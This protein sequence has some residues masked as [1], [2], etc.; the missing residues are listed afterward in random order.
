MPFSDPMAD[1]P[2]VQASSL[3]ALKSGQTMKK[4]LELVRAFR[5]SD[6]DTPIVLMGYYNPVYVY[7]ARALP[8][9]RQGRRRRRPHHRRPA[10]R[11]R[12]GAVPAGHRPR[13]QLHPPGHA[14]HGRQA[15]AGGA[16]QH[17]G[18]PLLCLH[19][20][21]H[22]HGGARRGR[23]P[24]PHCPNQEVDR[25][26]VAVGFGVKTPAQA[27]AIAAGADGV[28]VGQRWLTPFVIAWVRTAKATGKTVPNVLDLVKSLSRALRPA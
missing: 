5:A 13:P 24:C 9:R 20:R 22:R 26:P 28:V 19:Y 17:V 14:D 7:P 11:S 15:P 25:L 1:G 8:R 12:R 3:R 2:A 4:T 18:L 16:R 21:H 6:P 27:K 10:A 23:G